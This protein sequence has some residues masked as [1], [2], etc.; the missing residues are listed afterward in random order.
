MV[1]LN[2]DKTKGALSKNSWK[3]DKETK[4]A[5]LTAQVSDN[6]LEKFSLFV[7]KVLKDENIPPI[8][9]NFQIYFEKLLDNKPISFKKRINS[10]LETQADD[11][12]RAKMEREVKEGFA[13]T[14]SIMKIVSTVYK[15]INIMKEIVKKRI[16]ELEINSN[17][18]VVTNII[19]TLNEDLKRLYSLMSKQTEALKV[20]YERTGAILKKVES[21]TIFDSRFGIYNKRYLLKAIGSESESIEQLNHKSTLVVARIKESIIGKIVHSKD[22]MILTRN[23][24]KLLLKTSRR[25]DIVAHYGNGVFGILMKHT[26]INNAKRACERISDLIYATSFFLGEVE[27][28]TDIELAIVAISPAHTTELIVSTALDALQKTGKELEQ[29]IV[30]E[31]QEKSIE[32][33]K[34]ENGS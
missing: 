13:E 7:L 11:D 22:R 15:N 14:R 16:S 18:L 25:S 20:H 29:Y 21:G 3:D 2:K 27:I 32:I 23:I 5:S 24:A 34:G 17:Q 8:P 33:P 1:R 19:S 6:E 31:L 26:D 28:E 12:D 9:T 30:C 4:V 10:L